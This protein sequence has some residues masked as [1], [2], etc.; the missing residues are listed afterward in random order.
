MGLIRGIPITLWTKTQQG[1]DPFGAPIWTETAKE[2]DN[3]LIRPLSEEDKATEL[4][5]TGKKVV[6]ELC[7]PKGNA[8][9]WTDRKVTFYGEDFRTVGI[10]TEL[11]GFMVPLSWNKK[12]KVE[13][14]E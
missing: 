14:Y 5:L 9:E 4:N 6:Y 13:R 1:T 8:D 12:I 10:P 11:I 3:V 2:I 7:I